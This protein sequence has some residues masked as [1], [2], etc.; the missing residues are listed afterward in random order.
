MWRDC[1]FSAA[2]IAARGVLDTRLGVSAR[3]AMRAQS[4]GA[5]D[6]PRIMITNILDL[7]F[8]QSAAPFHAPALDC[9]EMLE[10]E[11]YRAF[12]NPE[13]PPSATGLQARFLALAHHRRA[14]ATVESWSAGLAILGVPVIRCNRR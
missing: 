10:L 6:V 2:S 1:D 14:P 4:L 11:I 12:D 9:S 8:R 13:A 5:G 7:G 3:V